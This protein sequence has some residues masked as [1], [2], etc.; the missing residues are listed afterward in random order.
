MQGK[1]SAAVIV[2]IF[3][4]RSLSTVF[5]IIVS[6]YGEEALG[7]LSKEEKYQES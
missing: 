4:G 1:R 3:F 6:F 2:I 5:V 7:S